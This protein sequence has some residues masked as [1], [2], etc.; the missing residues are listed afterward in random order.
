MSEAC[1]CY[2]IHEHFRRLVLQMEFLIFALELSVKQGEFGM[3]L[4]KNKASSKHYLCP[5][6]CDDSASLHS[7]YLLLLSSNALLT[8]SAFYLEIQ[9]AL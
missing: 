4:C 6:L 8:S 1:G 3:D 2:M 7:K 9:V 5:S